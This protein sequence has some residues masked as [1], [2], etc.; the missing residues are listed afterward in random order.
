[1]SLTESVI[2]SVK[3]GLKEGHLYIFPCRAETYLRVRQIDFP[4]YM[5]K[6]REGLFSFFIRLSSGDFNFK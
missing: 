6:W 3:T 5:W 1:M 2:Y 4:K